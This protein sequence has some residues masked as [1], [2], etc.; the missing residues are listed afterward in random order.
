MPTGT[1]KV[2]WRW[3]VV[4]MAGE[5]LRWTRVDQR[6]VAGDRQHVLSGPAGPLTFADAPALRAW[7]AVFPFHPDGAVR[8]EEPP[9]P[10]LAAPRGATFRWGDPRLLRALRTDA[11]LAIELSRDAERP[12]AVVVA[13]ALPDEPSPAGVNVLLDLDPP[14]AGWSGRELRFA[15]GVRLRLA[16]SAPDGP[17]IQ[18]HVIAG[19]R[20]EIG[21]SVQLG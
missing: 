18:A 3:P 14:G 5:R 15:D 8:P 9:Y 7:S 2:L 1:V 16:T 20:M 10:L 21:E 4:P 6:G 11:E 13:F 17:G 19:G 12:R